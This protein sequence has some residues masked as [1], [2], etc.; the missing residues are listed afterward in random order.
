MSEQKEFK[1]AREGQHIAIL[2]RFIRAG[3]HTVSGYQGAPDFEADQLILNWELTD[4]QI[5]EGKPFWIRTFGI[6]NINDY[7][8]E[9]SKKTKL[10]SNMF[11]DYNYNDRDA[12]KYLG[13]ACILVIKHNAG[14]G[15]HAGKTFANFGGVSM[16]PDVLPPVEYDL[17]QPAV[18][19]DFY[20][21]SKESWEQLK[22]FEQEY[23]KEAVNYDGSKL[24]DMLGEAPKDSD[25]DF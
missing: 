9:K 10:F 5:E 1:M 20:N 16:Y 22:P 8:T 15:K 24:Q 17:V 7:D 25:P 6:G 11:S 4:D 13:R 2:N 21:P 23:I 12:D 14:T 19:F 3:K 18:H